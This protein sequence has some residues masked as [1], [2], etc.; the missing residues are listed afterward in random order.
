M[1]TAFDAYLRGLQSLLDRI[2]TTQQDAI[3]RAGALVS[4]ALANGGILHVFGSGHSH[5]VAEDAFYRTGGLAAVNP[6]L[7]DRITFARGA[8]A[9]TRAEREPGLAAA[10][11]ADLDVR[12]MDVAIV[13]SNS[14]RNAAPIEMAQ[15]MKRRGV[16][17]IAITNVEQSRNVPS[18]HDSGVRLFEVADVVIDTCVPFG[19]ALAV[20]PALPG[21]MGPASTVAGSAIIHAIA[22]Q[23]AAA[24]LTA[25]RRAPILPSANVDDTTEEMLRT[26]LGPYRGR[27]KYLD[28]GG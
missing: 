22:I 11:L 3:L 19:D 21:P 16:A 23:A 2:R 7:D 25:G 8:L 13:V 18:R 1:V 6:I 12:P 9:S 26:I 24:L 15:E 14:G 5:L 17:T 20:D 10:L 4:D 27:V 28:V